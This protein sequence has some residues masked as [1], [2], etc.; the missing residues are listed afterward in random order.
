MT[1]I[2]SNGRASIAAEAAI[3]AYKF[4]HGHEPPFIKLYPC[5]A[6]ETGIHEALIIQIIES[7]C[8]SNA[9]QNKR[10][11]FHYEEWWTSLTYSDWEKE[12][13]FLGTERSI[14]K[15]IVAMEKAGYI[16]SCQPQKKG[17]SSVKFYRINALKVGAIIL[18]AFSVGTN[19]AEPFNTEAS[20]GTNSAPLRT[21]SAPLRTNSAD[22]PPSKSLPEQV[23][24]SLIDQVNIL[25]QSI[26]AAAGQSEEMNSHEEEEEVIP[27]IRPTVN[28][29]DG[30]ATNDKTPHEDP[31]CGAA[32][33]DLQKHL[34]F[35]S[36]L[37]KEFD[38]LSYYRSHQKAQG[39]DIRNVASYLSTTLSKGD[40]GSA[41]VHCL[42]KEWQAVCGALGRKIADFAENPDQIKRQREKYDFASWDGARHQAYFERLKSEGF[43]VFRSHELSSRWYEWA[44]AK[45]PDRFID[46]P[47]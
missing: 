38:F 9:R 28:N 22:T 39:K 11:Y 14:R 25:T 37:T 2:T 32:K 15:R 26:T 29:S 6:N 40:E 44:L 23:S 21:N 17:G 8:L 41:E 30:F 10:G 19:S 35:N 4:S 18:N 12:Y 45:H 27:D 47:A 7:W 34:T 16:F 24:G 31:L 43:A 46:I 1:S 3:A 20:V 13:P 36:D 42:Y 33:N 5:I